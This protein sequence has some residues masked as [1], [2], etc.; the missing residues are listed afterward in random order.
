MPRK[1]QDTKIWSDLTKRHRPLLMEVACSEDSILSKEVCDRFGPSAAFRCSIWNGFDLTTD[2]GV[3]RCKTMIETERPC[4]VWLSCECGPFSPMQHINQRTESQVEA[5]IEKRNDA[6]RQYLGGIEVAKHAKL[7][8]SQVHWELSERCEAWKLPF[9]QQFLLDLSLQTVVCHGCAVGLRTRSTNELLCKAWK[10]AST[11]PILVKRMNLICQKNHKKGSC[12]KGEAKHTA[13]YTPVFAKKVVDSFIEGEDWTEV[14]QEIFLGTGDPTVS[15]TER[16]EQP[17]ED[18]SGVAVTREEKEKILRHIQHIHSV[19]GHC[20]MQYLLDALKRRGVPTKVLDIAKRFQCP[21]CQERRR[22]DP[23]LPSSLDMIHKKWQVVQTDVADWTH[24]DNLQKYKFVIF[25]DEGSRYR[26]GA[27]LANPRSAPFPEIREAFE[28]HWLQ[29][30]GKPEVLRVDPCGAWRSKNAE[31]YLEDNHI[32]IGEIP[33]EAHWKIGLVEASIRILKDMLSAM[34]REYPSKPIKELFNKAIWAM[35]NRTVYNGFSPIQHAMGRSPDECGRLHE[36]TIQ[37]IPIHAQQHADGGFEDLQ[38]LMVL[39]ETEFLKAQAKQ[40][41]LR[42]QRA[43]HRTQVHYSPGDLVFYW[44][45]TVSKQDGEQPF[46]KGKFVGPARVLATETKQTTEGLERSDIIW[47]HRSGRLIRATPGQLRPASSREIAFEE[48]KGP[49]QV[50]WNISSLPKEPG[51]HSYEDITKDQPTDM[52]YEQDFD[53]SPP[54]VRHRSKRPVAVNRDNLEGKSEKIARVDDDIVDDLFCE[55]AFWA[56]S[57]ASV[58][59]EIPV[60]ESNR[61]WKTF[62]RDAQAFVAQQLKKKQVEVKEKHLSKTELDQFRVA[63]EKE[64]SNYLRSEC[65]EAL[66]PELRPPPHVAMKMRWLLVWKFTEENSKKA[67]ARIVIQGYQDPLYEYRDASAPVVSR[68]GRQCFLQKCAQQKFHVSKGDVTGAFL[69]GD[70]CDQD[71]WC[72]PTE[73]LCQALKVPKNSVCRLRKAA[74]GLVQAPLVWYQSVD[75]CFQSIGY[76]R[77]QSD[78]CIWRFNDNHGV[79]RSIIC[80]HVDVFLFGGK[81][82]DSIHEGLIKQIKSRFNWGS[83]EKSTFVQCGTKITQKPDC[84]FELTQE[85]F[86]SS[87]H[88]IP[89][90]KEKSR[91]PDLHTTESEKSQM[92]SVLGALSWYCGQVGY[93]YSADVGFLISSIPKSTIKDVIEM[94]NLV[95][96]IKRDKDLKLVIHSFPEH[97]PLHVV[98]WCDAAWANRPDGSSS[99]AGVLVGMSSPGLENGEQS[100]ISIISWRSSKIDRICRSP[101]AAETKAAVECD[102]DLFFVR[103][104]WSEIGGSTIDMKNPEV[105]AQDV[106]AILVTDSRNVYDKVNKPVMVIKGSE[107][108]SDIEGLIIKESMDHSSLQTRWVHSDAQL[109]NSLT[110]PGEKHQ[111]WMFRRMNYTWKI[112]DDPKMASAR[113][114]KKEGLEAMQD[115]P[116]TV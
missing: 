115:R 42:A 114:R 91:Q 103:T 45:L 52:E 19:T 40:R 11:S 108:R 99:T 70:I 104:M 44:R 20:S 74:Y 36:S 8:G 2:T 109:G 82:E 72:I 93:M 50:P 84:S 60:P 86:L 21:S 113:T 53:E 39:A 23:R 97:L 26:S 57:T 55:S 37:G 64:V 89:V 66:P 80:G 56:D 81:D 96:S 4:H 58:S 49:L 67:K 112:V 15:F 51:K 105:T 34:C 47:L 30:F 90:S 38:K 25:V 27:V 35:N 100:P 101:G 78:P 14:A 68:T 5:L 62:E 48:L 3:Q 73:E 28:S 43:G 87:V 106:P 83:W 65:L 46:R 33:A 61:Q 76:V 75:K 79:L 69:Q 10:I 116:K 41:I 98:G 18:Y 24:P 12:D 95:Y 110:K 6:V 54:L 22:P 13:F 7:W 111:F 59:F 94:N 29:H 77:L 85:S 88:E 31:K 16:I 107:K 17:E 102:D 1:C 92:R 63:K 9:I 71:L 32:E